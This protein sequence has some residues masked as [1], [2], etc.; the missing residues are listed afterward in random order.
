[1]DKIIMRKNLRNVFTI[2]AVLLTGTI[3]AIREDVVLA[4]EGLSQSKKPHT[5]K[6]TNG[7]VASSQLGSEVQ[8]D[9]YKIRPP[10]SFVFKEHERQGVQDFYR[11]Q[12]TSVNGHLPAQLIV[13]VAPF[14]FVSGKLTEDRL[15]SIYKATLWGMSLSIGLS[16][17]QQIT[18][19][20][21]SVNGVSFVSGRWSGR[22]GNTQFPWY[23]FIYVTVLS[24]KELSIQGMSQ[25]IPSLKLAEEATMTFHK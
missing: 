7:K 9:A 12:G 8:I 17:F 20:T 25:D 18:P 5:S 4:K 11:W 14:P 13:T 16:N 23:G 24:G 21:V 1:M 22:G 19:S 15:R 3:F 6:P 10:K 2:G